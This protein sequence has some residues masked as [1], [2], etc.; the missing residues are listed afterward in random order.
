MSISQVYFFFFI[1]VKNS[2]SLSSCRLKKCIET[3]HYL[4]FLG[5]S[6][7]CVGE[8]KQEQSLMVSVILF[9]LSWHIFF[10]RKGSEFA[11]WV[12]C[13]DWPKFFYSITSTCCVGCTKKQK[14][15][16]FLQ[17]NKHRNF[18]NTRVDCHKLA[19]QHSLYSV[20]L[21]VGADPRYFILYILTSSQ[22]SPIWSII[23]SI[24]D[25]ETVILFSQC[26]I[27]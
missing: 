3:V 21:A 2:R 15:T 22:Y 24:S 27:G 7:F 8:K 18:S 9:D 17:L 26:K 13:C 20:D 23:E 1:P 10:I 19:S 14:L 4:A 16:V 12:T 11:C 5:A 25:C 6:F